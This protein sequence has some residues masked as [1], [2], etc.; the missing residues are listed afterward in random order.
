MLS[1]NYSEQRQDF[2]NLP[3]FP[4]LIP[5]GKKRRIFGHLLTDLQTPKSLVLAFVELLAANLSPVVTVNMLIISTAWLWYV[6]LIQKSC[7]GSGCLFLINSIYSYG[8]GLTENGPDLISVFKTSYVE[9]WQS[10]YN[11][12]DISSEGAL[13]VFQ[14]IETRKEHRLKLLHPLQILLSAQRN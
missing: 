11:L 5:S 13:R 8:V 12:S 4:T 6:Q 9:I 10:N 3:Y 1:I 7:L 2:L 14:L